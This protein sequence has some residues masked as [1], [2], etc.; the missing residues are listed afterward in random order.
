MGGPGGG[1]RWIGGA[2]ARFWERVLALAALT[3]LALL[4]YRILQPFLAPMAWAVFLAFLLQ[5]AQRRLAALLGGRA[6]AAALLLTVGML[7]LFLGPLTALAIAF[8]SQA[9]EL[10]AKLQ[11]W[12]VELR[13]RDLSELTDWPLLRTALDWLEEHAI[14][15]VAEVQAWLLQGARRLLERLASLGGAAFLGAAGTLLSFTVMLFLL[16]FFVRD[17]ARMARSTTQLIPLSDARR[18]QLLDRLGDVTR[19]VVLG[20]VLTA[21]IQGALLGIG[22]AVVGLPAPVVFG[23]AA[24]VLSVVPFGGTALVWVPAVG[25]LLYQ[26]AW[27][28]AAV[29]T[30]VGVV[31]GSVDNFVKPMLISGRA[32]V[33]TLAVFVGVLG[34]LVA[35]GMIGMFIGPVVIAVALTL[36]RFVEE[37]AAQ[38]AE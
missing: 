25:V 37:A 15:S 20:T 19:A 33:P 32:V 36:L 17:G 14:V 2:D 9:A 26:A 34:G 12:L 35:F 28:D 23:V 16:F 22:F 7:A 24:A 4:L 38:R 29:L 21:V 27:V 8:A 13:G 3:L 1:F 10:A 31:V 11:G 30:G 6:S 18:R 5:P